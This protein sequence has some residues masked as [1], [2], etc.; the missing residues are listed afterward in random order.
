[1]PSGVGDEESELV[2]GDG[3]GESSRERFAI[4]AVAVREIYLLDPSISVS[5]F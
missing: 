1:M 4:V 5:L 2:S 3:G